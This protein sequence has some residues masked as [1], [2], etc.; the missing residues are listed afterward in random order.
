MLCSAIL[1]TAFAALA[2]TSPIR[3]N[4]RELVVVTDIITDIVVVTETAGVPGTSSFA[5]PNHASYQS[6]TYNIA[7]SV[8][9]SSSRV[10]SQGSTGARITSSAPVLATSSSYEVSIS[11]SP[12]IS[13]SDAQPST[14]AS[15]ILD[16]HNAHRANHSA[17]DLVWDQD[18]ANTATKIA[19]SCYYAHNIAM[20]GGGYGQNIAAGAPASNISAVITNSFYNGEVNYFDG[21]YGE[22]SPDM[23]KFE[24]W[25]HFSQIVWKATGFVGCAV[26]NCTSQGLGNVG[27]DVAP[28]FTVCNYKGA[29]MCGV[30]S[31]YSHLLTGNPGNVGGEYGEN[32]GQ[33]LGH[34][35]I[36]YD[37]FG[38]L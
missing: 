25:G 14:F 4:K 15:M 37:S 30:P 19:D 23:S 5:T 6:S 13:G 3:L 28:F 17:P 31:S 18:L 29:G 34:P 12:F 9:V 21:L 35:T 2:V 24:N 16:H 11:V 20:D 27:A 36:N 38:L 8:S 32:I 1:A 7:A 22:A 26:R 33:P 10:A